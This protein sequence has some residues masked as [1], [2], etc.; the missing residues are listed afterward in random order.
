MPQAAADKQNPQYSVPAGNLLRLSDPSDSLSECRLALSETS[1]GLSEY[2]LGLSEVSDSLS[3]H[4]LA[5]SEASDDAKALA[6]SAN[7]AKSCFCK[8]LIIN[9][10]G[11]G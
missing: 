5:L 2:R 10:I 9:A 4:W 1:D 8:L 7:D 6:E 11:G 3:W